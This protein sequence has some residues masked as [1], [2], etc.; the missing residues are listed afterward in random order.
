MCPT[1]QPSD[2]NPTKVSIAVNGKIKAIFMS[3]C[4]RKGTFY[5]PHLPVWVNS[6]SAGVALRTQ[7]KNYTGQLTPF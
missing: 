1:D 3:S 2:A 7:W 5:Q 4:A 6:Y